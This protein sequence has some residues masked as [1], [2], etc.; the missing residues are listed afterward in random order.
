MASDKRTEHILEQILRFTASDFTVRLPV[1]E[2]GDELD[3]IIAGLNTIGEELLMSG[4]QN[5]INPDFRILFESAPGLYLVLLP[6]KNFTIVAVS[7]A[8]ANATM[9]KRET[10]LSKGLFEVFPDNPD[11]PKADGVSNLRASL[12]FVLKNKS[13]H[14]M[15]IQ[16]YDIR[17]ADGTFEERHWSPLNSPVLA[18]DG[19]LSYIIHRVEDVTELMRMK[20]KEGENAQ[21]SA[22][23]ENYENRINSIF[24]SLLKYTV[25]DFSQKAFISDRGDEIDA[26]AA[27][28]NTL[29]EEL[30]LHIAELKKSEE[31]FRLLINGVKDYA[32]YMIDVNGNIVSW[33]EGAKKIK[34]YGS[35]EVI[36]KH[37]SI[38]YTPEDLKQKAPDH[39]LKM[40]SE[41]G[42]YE[43][44]GW[45]M[46]K[47]GSAFWADVIFTALYDDAG[48][49]YGFSKIT[50]DITERKKL[51]DS[52]KKSNE[53][54]ETINKELEAFTYSV[55]HD[56]RAPLRAIDGYAQMLDE[57]YNK[58][59]DDEGKRL[60]STV[61]YNAKKMGILIDDLL[62]FSRLGRKEIEKTEIDMKELAQIALAE[63]GR[64][65]EHKANVKIKELQPAF[66]DYALMNQVMVN[67]ISNAIK[68]SSKTAKP[69]IE[70][71]SEQKNREVI[72][73]VKD[74]GAGF[75]M[76][77]ANKLF[78]V[79][80]RLHKQ[81]EFEGTGVGLAIVQ[82]I[83]N[84]HGGKVWAEGE[85]GK[86]ATFF[87]SLP[88]N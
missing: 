19:T 65:K 69:D 29:A 23:I 76:Q 10:I 75:D 8:Y 82:R 37:F 62:A 48:K 74:N 54:L 55:S 4:K 64:M 63:A 12:S 79:F 71:K 28:L 39:N 14:A 49:L 30:E 59:L 52:L 45:R 20:Q 21:L 42:N 70:I 43:S 72:Y 40:A 88:V 41:K 67:L 1:S 80:Q 11:D 87:F 77:Y 86:G 24:E 78:G 57:D 61:Q 13:A 46:K 15:A 33:N 5:E 68:Y 58:K 44:E 34:G 22:T 6:D 32:I 85:T 56:L 16:K 84:K 26:F 25:M 3:A 66:A 35:D 27:G 50:R 17:R 36:G 9:T 73:S 53:Q 83:I 7:N 81:E 2:K 31:R 38:F 47:N 51:E 60:L 18:A